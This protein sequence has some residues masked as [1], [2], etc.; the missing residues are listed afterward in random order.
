MKYSY[1]I[2]EYCHRFLAMYIQPG[3]VCVDATAGNGFDT[4]FLCRLCG[5]E[6]RVYAFDIQEEAILSTKERLENCGYENRVCL[7]HDGHEKMGEYV[8]E[9]VS[10]IV[11]NFGYLPG[12]DHAVATRPE[13]SIR[14]VEEGLNLLKK[15]GVMC[16]C[17]YS[18]RDTGYEERDVLLSY[19][20]ELDSKHWLVIVN[21]YFNRKN[22]PPLPVFIIRLK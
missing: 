2:T 13:T 9:C 10:A 6:G 21:Q 14:A 22:D 15:D 19:L 11:F 20:K 17:I 16:L 8:K 4:E 7:I 3:D 1:Q 18:G 12:A 5:E